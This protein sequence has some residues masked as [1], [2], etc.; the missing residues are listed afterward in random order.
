MQVGKFGTKLFEVSASRVYTFDNLNISGSLRTESGDAASKKPP[1]TV[2]GAGL[3]KLSLTL[4]L[5]AA[6]GVDVRQEVEDWL[7]LLDAGKAYPFILCGRAVSVNSFL[8]VS[9]KQQK[10]LIVGI[11]RQAVL[12]SCELALEFTEYLPPGIQLGSG[13]NAGTAGSS[14]LHAANPYEMPDSLEK[15]MR[16]RENPG[17][18]G[19]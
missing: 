12:T 6:F 11:G 9:V 1:T 17:M 13:T 3:L 7:A 14:G 8:L 19:Y 10:P 18:S 5:Q 15:A 16:K 4:K 2:K